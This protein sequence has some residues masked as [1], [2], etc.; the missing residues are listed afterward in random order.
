MAAD[1][2]VK[3]V[4][5]VGTFECHRTWRRPHHVQ[6][7]NSYIYVYGMYCQTS[8]Q[9]NVFV[10]NGISSVLFVPMTAIDAT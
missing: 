7:F 10:L 2:Q 3:V 1:K 5:F 6:V 8:N 4:K 9:R